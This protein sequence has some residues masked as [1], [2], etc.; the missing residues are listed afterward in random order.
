VTLTLQQL[1]TPDKALIFR[2][3][4]VGNLQ[5][6]LDNGAHCRSSNSTASNYVQIGNAELIEKRRSRSVPIYPGGALSDYVPFYFTPASPM[7]FNI[8]TGWGGIRQ[9]SNEEIVVLVLSLHR[10]IE[11]GMPFV[12]T[13]RHAYLAAAS[14]FSNLS[15]LKVLDWVA[16]QQ[17]RFN[18]DPNDP[19]KFERYQAEALVYRHVPID[20][21]M[22]IGCYNAAVQAH[23]QTE[24][25][26][27]SLTL[28]VAVRPT[29]FF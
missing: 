3:V 10:L 16:L 13:D 14:F 17:K 5:W 11:R 27:R 6:L 4:H 25:N 20:A 28:Q 19:E 8:K 23:I 7:L 2:I 22:G 9:R 24:L 15:D 18:R 1:L 12:F 26:S 29:W 21:L